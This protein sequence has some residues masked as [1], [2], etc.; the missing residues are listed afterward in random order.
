MF[1]SGLRGQHAA[2]VD[3]YHGHTISRSHGRRKAM[4]A[5]SAGGQC[6]NRQPQKAGGV[7]PPK[8]SAA[9]AQNG[10]LYT[11]SGI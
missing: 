9:G 2:M 7:D 1:L 8:M 11:K 6:I 4:K 3:F 10:I 5:W